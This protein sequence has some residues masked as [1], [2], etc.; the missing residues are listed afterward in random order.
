MLNNLAVA[1][2]AGLVS[3]TSACVLPLVPAYVAYLGGVAAPSGQGMQPSRR[4]PVLINAILFVAGFATAFTGLGASAGLL[5]ANLL[6]YRP[7]LTMISGLLLIVMGIAL[8]GGIP[9][10]MQEQR[11]Q[12]VRRLPRSPWASYLIGVAFAVGWTPCV[13]PILAAVLLQA[14]NTATAGQGALLL[15]AYSAGMGIPFIAA[16]FFMAPVSALI[17]RVRG[18][19]MVMNWAAAV[20]LVLI[21]LLTVTNRLTLLNSYFPHLAPVVVQAQLEGS[22]Q[23]PRDV[24][25]LTGHPVPAVVVTGLDG[26]QL[27]LASLRGKPIIVSFWATWCIPCRDELPLLTATYRAHTADDVAL[28]AIDYQE[29]P[30]AVARFWQDLGLSPAPYVDSDG[31]ASRQF[32]IDVH[33][34]GLPVTVFVGRDG[35]VRSVVP[36]Q[37]TPELLQARLPALLG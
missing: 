21:G 36:G 9:W 1:L 31:A 25:G 11:L 6:V 35:R 18:A 29:S 27:S 20:L 15:L 12:L 23:P 4:L 37:L 13:G 19:Y 5:G 22:S 8:V 3:C 30:A 16:A 26:H 28:V 32:G 24:T 7:A 2:L 34:T 17:R 33:Q 14:A 10:L